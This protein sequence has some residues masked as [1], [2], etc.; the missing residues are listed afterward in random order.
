ME[1]KSTSVV[2]GFISIELKS[3]SVELKPAP[4]VEARH[5]LKTYAGIKNSVLATTFD[6]LT[7]PQVTTHGNFAEL[8]KEL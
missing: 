3:K 5:Y 6:V 1:A 8:S 4:T 2:G 7:G